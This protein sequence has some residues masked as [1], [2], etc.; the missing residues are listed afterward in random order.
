MPEERT[1]IWG[2]LRAQRDI[3]IGMKTTLELHLR[4]YVERSN[5]H[6]TRLRALEER[7]FPLATIAVVVGAVDLII[8]LVVGILQFM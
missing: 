3:M 5:D 1:S 4:G 7:R 6:E 8:M 2:E